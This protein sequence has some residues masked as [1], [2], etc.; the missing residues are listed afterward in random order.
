MGINQNTTPTVRYI[1]LVWAD[2]QMATAQVRHSKLHES[3]S[4]PLAF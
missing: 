2:V 4:D 3:W 1:E